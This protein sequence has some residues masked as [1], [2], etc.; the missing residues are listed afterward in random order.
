MKETGTGGK[1]PNF[2]L[3]EWGSSLPISTCVQSWSPIGIS[4]NHE[5]DP[6]SRGY[7]KFKPK[8]IILK[9]AISFS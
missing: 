8:S 7:F 2:G 5:W 6:D 9:G 1:M 3:S 4:L